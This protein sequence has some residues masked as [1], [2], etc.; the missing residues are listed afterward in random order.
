MQEQSKK[1]YYEN[2][3]E[4]LQEKNRLDLI[5]K[6]NKQIRITKKY[7]EYG[8]IPQQLRKNDLIHYYQFKNS[9]IRTEAFYADL[10]ELPAIDGLDFQKMR[11]LSADNTHDLIKD[12]AEKIKKVRSKSIQLIESELNIEL[13]EELKP[14]GIYDVLD[15]SSTAYHIHNL[16]L[17]LEV[18]SNSF[19]AVEPIYHKELVKCIAISLFFLAVTLPIQKSILSFFGREG[20]LDL[21]FAFFVLAVTS[22]IYCIKEHRSKIRANRFFHSLRVG[23]K[24]IPFFWKCKKLESESANN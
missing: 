13:P 3:Q 18:E 4:Q 10:K 1:Q 22:V 15:P 12:I 2:L 20:M 17:S 19:K 21:A 14:Y 11:V 16:K 6:K 9:A 8:R 23:E 7:Y 5:E 24:L